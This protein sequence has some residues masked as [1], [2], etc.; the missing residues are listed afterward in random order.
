MRQC[1]D[2][3]LMRLHSILIKLQDQLMMEPGL[4]MVGCCNELNAGYAADGYS[5]G[6]GIGCVVVTHMVGGLSVLNA[7]AGMVAHQDSNASADADEFHHCACRSGLS[8]GCCP[9]PS[10]EQ[11][12]LTLYA[13]AYAEHHP[14]ICV[15]GIPVRPYC[16]AM[17][18]A[19]HLP[20]R[21]W[22]PLHV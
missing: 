1:T 10:F 15:I 18:E 7:I 4:D 13:G 19:L 3:L 20:G 21:R 11:H 12:R 22:L 17:P 6:A 5:R 16:L 9:G 2:Y 14:V 8:H